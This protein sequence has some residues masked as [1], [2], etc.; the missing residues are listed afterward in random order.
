M[1]YLSE[2]G[3]KVIIKIVYSNIICHNITYVKSYVCSR[4]LTKRIY[5]K[6]NRIYVITK[7]HCIYY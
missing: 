5:H 6:N 4:F 1:H 2:F 3:I 7:H